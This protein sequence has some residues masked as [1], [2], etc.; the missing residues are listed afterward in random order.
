M[1]GGEKMVGTRRLPSWLLPTA[2]FLHHGDGIWRWEGRAMIWIGRHPF[3]R[4][5]GGGMDRLPPQGPA[6]DPMG[7]AL[8]AQLLPFF[9]FRYRLLSTEPSPELAFLPLR[10]EIPGFAANTIPVQ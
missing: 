5:G 1:S 7:H 4:A 8:C 6:P 3:D 10:S 9:G 2:C